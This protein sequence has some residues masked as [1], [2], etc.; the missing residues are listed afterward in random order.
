M[1]A[2]A[3]VGT[4]LQLGSSAHGFKALRSCM[5]SSRLTLAGLLMA[6]A[7]APFAADAQPYG[8]PRGY[9][10]QYYEDYNERYYDYGRPRYRRWSEPPYEG[11]GPTGLICAVAPQYRSY[12][13][14]CPAAANF[15]PGEYCECQDGPNL[16]PGEIRIAR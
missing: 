10:P 3:P 5:M 13:T 8:R 14:H 15:R 7:L 11:P 16:W 2:A 9:G 1:S 6:C 12:R 4:N